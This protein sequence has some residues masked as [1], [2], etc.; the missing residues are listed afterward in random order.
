[1]V[2]LGFEPGAAGRWAQT[3]PRSYFLYF[4]YYVNDA[5]DAPSVHTAFTILAD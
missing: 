1:M 5:T 2:C 3:K 4:V